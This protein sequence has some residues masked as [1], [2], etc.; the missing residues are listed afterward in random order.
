M[1][2]TGLSSGWSA[3]KPLWEFGPPRIARVRFKPPFVWVTT[4]RAPVLD[5]GDAAFRLD[6]TSDRI[7]MRGSADVFHDSAV[8]FQLRVWMGQTTGPNRQGPAKWIPDALD[9]RYSGRCGKEVFDIVG[10]VA[11]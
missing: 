8:L 2:G 1:R 10:V 3:D 9:L 11:Q 7:P 4:G 6:L 5:H